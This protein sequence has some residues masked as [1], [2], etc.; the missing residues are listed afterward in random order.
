MK[1]QERKRAREN[2]IIERYLTSREGA[3]PPF[4]YLNIYNWKA[5]S[6]TLF[7]AVM[8]P[9]DVIDVEGVMSNW[10]GTWGRKEQLACQAPDV[11]RD[12]KSF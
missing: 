4:S 1:K 3:D 2:S 5:R 8:L 10:E 9:S 7:N 6:V 11:R 12:W